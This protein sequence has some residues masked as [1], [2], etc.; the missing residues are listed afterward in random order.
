VQDRSGAPL[1][2]ARVKG[3]SPASSTARG[4]LELGETRTDD[5]GRFT[6]TVP[7]P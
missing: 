2:L 6:L 3:Y 1:R 4:A 7:E 5:T